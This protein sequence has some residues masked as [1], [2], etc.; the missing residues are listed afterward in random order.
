MRRDDICIYVSPADRA[1]LEGIVADRKSASKHA[2]RAKIVL[3]TAEGLGTN[4]IMRLTSKSKPCV[5]RWQ[6]R[7]IE[8]GVDGLLRD[9]TRPSR[10]KPLSAEV[11]LKVL[12]TTMQ[13]P[14]NA[15]HG[16]TRSMAK[17]VGIS[18]S[19]VQSRLETALGAHVQGLERSEI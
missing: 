12:P 9:K 19:S 2:W 5:W 7:Y 8:T 6:E 14:P 10:K 4:A 17:A 18:H 13:P 1:R 11:K 16:S 3:A 15:T